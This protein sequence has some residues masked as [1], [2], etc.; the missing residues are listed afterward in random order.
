MY[1]YPALFKRVAF[2]VFL[3]FQSVKICELHFKYNEFPIWWEIAAGLLFNIFVTGV[4]AFAVF[5]LPV[6]RLLPSDYYRIEDGKRLINFSKKIG[7]ESFRRF[8]LA[9]VWQN[10][11]K[12]KGYFDGSLAGLQH[13]IINTKKSE[14]GHLLPFVILTGI[15]V[16]LIFYTKFLTAFVTFLINIIFNFYPI[17]LQRQHRVRTQRLEKI[18][19]NRR[20]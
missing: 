2:A 10:K 1:Q 19:Q 11:E 12:Q 17:I 9:T 4:F 13:F 16:V 7:I 8:L 20:V 5:A 15:S 6:E 14:F 3:L 18:L